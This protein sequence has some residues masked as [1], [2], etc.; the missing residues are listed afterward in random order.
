MTAATS[1]SAYGE[2]CTLFTRL[3]RFDHLSAIAG[4]DM[5]TMMPPGGSKARAEALAELSVLRHQLLSAQTTG[6]LLDRAWQET[7]S[8]VER[9][10]LVEMR[11]QYDNAVVVPADL[12]EAKWL[13]GA[14]CEH[15]W[16]VQRPAND[17]QGFAENLQEVV[18]LSRQEAQIRAQ[19]AGCGRYDALLAM[20]EPGLRSS[21]LDRIFADLTTWLPDL[22]QRVVARQQ[23]EAVLAP[24]G[25]FD[26]ERQRQ[27]GLSAMKLLGF[28]FDAGRVDVSAHP[29][30]GG[31]PEDVR[32]TTR[33]NETEFLTALMGIVHETG[34]ARYEQNL[35][36]EWLGQPISSARSTAIHES[37]SL[38]FEMQLARTE[39]FLK[40]L[41]PLVVAQ[42]G[43]Q[44]ALAEDNFI[45]LNQQVKPGLIRVN[46]D[47]VSYP[48]HI[49][50][51][52]E[53][54]KALIEGDI[55]VA[56][57]P[58]LWNEKMQRYLGLDTVGNY[59]D[60]CMQDIHW[61]DGAFGYF[62]TYTLGAMYAAQLFNAARQA[63][64]TLDSDI[65]QG[66][67]TSL[68][69][70]LQQNIWQHGSR[71]PTAELIGNA[72]GEPLNPRYFRQHLESRYL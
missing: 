36:R 35:P 12:V 54:E 40:H 47:E 59:R 1:S 5:Q 15:A 7:L 29:F 65:A 55:E 33:Y 20:F 31:V 32:I 8:D 16:R 71:Y 24:Q 9:A 41:R 27:L 10:N 38:L 69:H 17:W 11:R 22:L 30:C 44:P 50:L 49:I 13:A 18:K 2:L 58:A 23:Q 42:F 4:W 14:R 56:D 37:Q 67:L 62:P 3:A 64:P 51:R 60:G 68:F 39:G 57:I 72:T 6:A 53:I 34:H 66:N 19:A 48:A 45:R 28:N 63:I 61:T 43:E 21:E 46:A 26:I 25:P 52:Y 70:W